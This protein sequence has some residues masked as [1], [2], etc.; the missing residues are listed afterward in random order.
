MIQAKLDKMV[1]LIP[2]SVS[3]I[4]NGKRTMSALKLIRVAK[5]FKAR[6]TAFLGRE[7]FLLLIIF[8]VFLMEIFKTFSLCYGDLIRLYA[9]SFL[10]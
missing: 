8:S 7:I 9:F 2:A 1:G 6:V 10:T 5:A 4:K 3:K